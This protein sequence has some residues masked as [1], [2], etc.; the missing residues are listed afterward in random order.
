MSKLKLSISIYG[1][2]S[3]CNLLVLKLLDPRTEEFVH[4]RSVNLALSVRG[5]TALQSINAD[6]PVSKNLVPVYQMIS[7]LKPLLGTVLMLSI[8]ILH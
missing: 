4:G 7:K 3:F 6:G 2:K 1:F 8:S 5:I